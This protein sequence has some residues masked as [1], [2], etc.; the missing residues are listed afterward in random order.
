[1]STFP[2][3]ACHVSVL[4]SPFESSPSESRESLWPSLSTHLSPVLTCSF[5][6]P[7]PCLHPAYGALSCH[8]PYPGPVCVNV[9]S[10]KKQTPP[11]QHKL[12]GIPHLFSPF[13][14]FDSPSPFCHCCPLRFTI[15]CGESKSHLIYLM[16]ERQGYS[17][18]SL[19]APL[20][21]LI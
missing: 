13:P 8:S 7:D 18:A 15:L 12:P 16:E 20:P 5:S 1:M 11:T 14:F 3:R 4:K 19:R 9:E 21:S 6:I 2:A 10:N 17:Y